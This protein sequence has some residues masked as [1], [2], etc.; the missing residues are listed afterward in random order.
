LFYSNRKAD[1]AAFIEELQAM[2][3]QNPNFT[4]VPTVTGDKHKTNGELN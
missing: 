1:D 4:F 3:A 2:A